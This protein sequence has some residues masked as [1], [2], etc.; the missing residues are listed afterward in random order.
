V[1]SATA[2]LTLHEQF[3][4]IRPSAMRHRSGWTSSLGKLAAFVG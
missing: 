4:T 2:A 1:P 3:V